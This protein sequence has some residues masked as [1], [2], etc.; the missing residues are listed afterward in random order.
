MPPQYLRAYPEV[1]KS[2]ALEVH[3]NNRGHLVLTMW[4]V[5]CLHIRVFNLR[6]D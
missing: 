1:D 5:S 4:D 3:L 6:S 2:V